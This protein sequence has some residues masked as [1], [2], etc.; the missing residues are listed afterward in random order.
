MLHPEVLTPVLKKPILILGLALIVTIVAVWSAE[1]QAVTAGEASQAR[2]AAATHHCP[3]P[4]PGEETFGP[5]G[6]FHEAK[7]KCDS[8]EHDGW[9]YRIEKCFECQVWYVFGR[10]NHF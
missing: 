6:T 10:R 9:H 3:R 5:Y 1:P 8:L 4:R 7:Q 2:L